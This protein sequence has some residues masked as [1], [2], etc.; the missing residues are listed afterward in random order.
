MGSK[1][2]VLEGYMKGRFDLKCIFI[3][4]FAWA[5]NA[6]PHSLK[7]YADGRGLTAALQ[8]QLKGFFF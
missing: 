2:L 3:S 8:H 5:G 7:T 1:N 6:E 4:H